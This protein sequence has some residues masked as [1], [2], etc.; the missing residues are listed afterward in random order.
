MS[1]TNP[2]YLVP[3]EE[4]TA[5]VRDEVKQ[6]IA[7]YM[8][9]IKNLSKENNERKREHNELLGQIIIQDDKMQKVYD[10]NNEM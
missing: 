8:R 6:T 1:G 5:A 4:F 3:R 7:P 2:T 10:Q 9:A